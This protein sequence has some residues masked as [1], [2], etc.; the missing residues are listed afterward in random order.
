MGTWSRFVHEQ[1]LDYYHN[2]R[3]KPGGLRCSI[4]RTKT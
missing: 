3:P 4:T 2:P 1:F